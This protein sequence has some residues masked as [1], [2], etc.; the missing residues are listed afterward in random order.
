MTPER[1]RQIEEL[2][3]S[4]RERD[5]GSRIAFLTTAC[6][7]DEDLRR[8]VESLLAQAS[9]GSRLEQPPWESGDRPLKSVAAQLPQGT[10]LGPYRID[11][12][13]GAVG[14]GEVYRAR[15]TRL[16]RDVAIKIS[17][18]QFT[19][20]FEREAR[21]IA[22]PNHPNICTL[23]DV[24]ANYL[25]MELV[26]GPT[27]ADRIK[28]GA[29]PLDE[30][31][32][33]AHQIA[34]AL[35]AAHERGIV[36]RDL[37]PAN[38]KIKPD[39]TVKVLDF[40]LATQKLNRDGEDATVTMTEPGTVLG[41]AAY[42]SPEQ[43]RGKP[44][45]KRADIWAFGAV[46]YEM[47]TG[48]R[49]FK[50]EAV[51]DVL[52]RVV[53]N[54]PDWNKA[55]ANVRRLLRRCLEKDPK[56]RLRDI[57]DAWELLEVG[58]G[59]ALPIPSHSKLVWGVAIAVVALAGAWW[60]WNSRSAPTA[61]SRNLRQ[62]TYDEG[63]TGFPALSPDAKLVA[64]QSDRAGPGRFDIWVQQTSGGSAIRLTKGPATHEHPVFSG[65]GSKVYFDSSGPP[66]GIY[67]ISALGGE[68]R[69]IAADGMW[70]RV[71]PDGRSI[72]YGG[73]LSHQLLVVPASGG[74]PHAV[75]PDFTARIAI[76]PVWSPD[77]RMLITNG[78]KTGQPETTE[79]YLVPVSGGT[80][81][82]LDWAHWAAEHKVN[83]ATGAWL[84]GEVFISYLAKDGNTQIY[85]THRSSV[86]TG[87]EILGEPEPL[88]FGGSLNE[89]P[90][91]AAGKIAFQSGTR[92]GAI[93]SLAADTNQ[94]RVTGALEKLTTEKANY[95]FVALTPDGK[96]MAFSSDRMG[97]RNDLF[98][99]DMVSGQDR[100][101]DAD[102]PNKFKQWPLI[103]A[104]GKEVV[105]S[106]P[107]PTGR[108]DVYVVP[109]QGGAK[110]KIC[111][112]CGPT[113]SLSP[114]GKQFLAVR[115]GNVGV[116]VVDVASGKSTLVLE[117]SQYRVGGPRFS[118]DGKWIVFL[119]QS[120][121][122]GGDVMV[123]PFRG[124]TRVPGQDWITVTPEPVPVGPPFWSPDGG[125]VY[126]PINVG[127]FSLM[128]R[129]LDRNH[130]P[131][132]APFRVFEFPGRLHG[133]G[134]A[135]DAMIAV[136]GRFINAM[137]DLSFNVWMMD[138]PK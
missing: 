38:I 77:S 21:S 133:Q 116:N 96:T 47:V 3:H 120:R 124:A 48:E 101:L 15:D 6:G 51:T 54:E 105:Y 84:P 113:E 98:L 44:V 100:T 112:A 24:G 131:V 81:R 50:G 31:L 76:R 20:R 73:L 58:Q 126:Y 85:R 35:E 19:S 95:G 107:D 4:A 109:A 8:E 41:T 135:S 91:L 30:S 55:P 71:S 36:H 110:R 53:N 37:K 119:I 11:A 56:R 88:T 57:G 60:L 79:G 90:F 137:S 59:H 102:D 104:S 118:P 34:D 75:A 103:D 25:V 108:N 69:L 46:L 17:S 28:R 136:P 74:E 115:W 26:E 66:Q 86:A 23:H 13:I 93:W 5:P 125:L 40:G 9:D 72:A 89:Y 138:L 65:D 14:M 68:P 82:Q 16:G 1:L 49:A 39:G 63:T 132:G 92:Q 70:P 129:R 52:A 12:P 122:R 22:A 99:R 43:A 61:G 114:D 18:E 87:I 64:Y 80:P 10:Q 94:G 42:M 127:G 2:Y 106:M 27:L 45:D 97:G 121:A 130:H 32:K 7:S 117:H 62:L 83:G 123:A 128:A 78:F 67:E 134:T 29:I 111:N 33:L